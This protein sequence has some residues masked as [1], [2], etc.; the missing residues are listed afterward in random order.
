MVQLTVIEPKTYI[1]QQK[2]FFFLIRKCKIFKR[3][4]ANRLLR[5]YRCLSDL[6]PPKHILGRMTITYSH[7]TTF[8]ERF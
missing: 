7:R 6:S 4:N 2:Y 3:M 5:R 8:D 1:G